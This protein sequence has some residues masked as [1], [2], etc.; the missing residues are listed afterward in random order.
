ML[1]L[2]I[3]IFEH[4]NIYGQKSSFLFLQYILL[5]KTFLT[6]CIPLIIIATLHLQLISQTA[7]CTFP[8]RNLTSLTNCLRLVMSFGAGF[9]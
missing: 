4:F 7:Y 5:L 8:S 1:I 9:L 3:Y 6:L 2:K